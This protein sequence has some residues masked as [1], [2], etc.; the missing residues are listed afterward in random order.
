MSHITCHMSCV[1]CH[2][3]RVM[4]PFFLLLF[5][6]FFFERG[7][8]LFGGRSVINGA[9][10]ET[11]FAHSLSMFEVKTRESFQGNC[12]HFL[13]PATEIPEKLGVN[14]KVVL[15]LP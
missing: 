3:S 14:I 15:G 12:D 9:N 4:C 8:K 11:C 6:F 5:F 13:E 2:V 7:V 1:T 10:I